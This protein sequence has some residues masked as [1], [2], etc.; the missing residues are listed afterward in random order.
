MKY[1]RSKP[2]AFYCV[3]CPGID[4]KPRVVVPPTTRPAPK[5]LPSIAFRRMLLCPDGLTLFK[6]TLHCTAFI[7]GSIYQTIRGNFR[8]QMITLRGRQ[9]VDNLC[10]YQQNST[11]TKQCIEFNGSE[12]P[13]CRYQ[14][15]VA[16]S[17]RQILRSET[18]NSNLDGRRWPCQAD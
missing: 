16:G 14:I 9:R 5:A 18:Q 2:C 6:L 7:I 1:H 4:C 10:R 15:L 13:H 17:Q 12:V 8:N 3:P 11:L